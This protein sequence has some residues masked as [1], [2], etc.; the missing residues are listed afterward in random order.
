MLL[1]ADLTGKRFGRLDVVKHLGYGV[2][3]CKCDCG[4]IT[5]TKTNALTSGVA[6]S[7]GCLHSE[8]VSKQGTKHGYAGTRL[9]KIW[10]NMKT[11]CN[12][13]S[14]SK[15]EIYGGRGIRVCNEWLT[16]EP[17][18]DW[19]EAN[20]YQ[21][22]L[23]IDRINS[24]GNYEPSNCRWTTYKIQGNNTKQNHILKFNGQEKTIAEWA[25]FL[26]FSYKVLS[27]RIRRKWTTERALTTPVDVRG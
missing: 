15:Y 11:R 5:T 8:I 12:T 9:Y 20:G 22:D 6:K 7:C 16:F 25:D 26:G 3:E 10:C 17:F 27:E 18:K 23:S 2:W 13:P 1:K 14:A 4:N 24:D 21:D 19:A